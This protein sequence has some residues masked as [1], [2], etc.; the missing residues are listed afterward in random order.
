MEEREDLVADMDS[1]TNNTSEDDSAG[2][3]DNV[4]DDEQDGND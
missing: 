4:I 2:L 1:D 3:S